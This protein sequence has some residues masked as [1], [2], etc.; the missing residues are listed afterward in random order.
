MS[1]LNKNIIDLVSVLKLAKNDGLSNKLYK[2]LQ[3]LTPSL[4]DY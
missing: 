1:R 4:L 3:L 2:E